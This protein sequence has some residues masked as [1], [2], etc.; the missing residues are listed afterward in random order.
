MKKIQKF[1]VFSFLVTMT[2]CATIFTGTKQIVQINSKPP[3]AKVQVDGID[4]GKTPV[5]LNLKKG[6]DGQVIIL[7]AEGYETKTF[8]PET[9]FN[10]ISILNFFNILC[11]G[12]DAATGALWKY[13]PKY[14]EVEL[15]PSKSSNK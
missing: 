9:T 13:D 4:R 8:Q 10:S 6:N 3:G 12:I 5:A 11:W 1:I 2:S 7:K 15:E 14:Y